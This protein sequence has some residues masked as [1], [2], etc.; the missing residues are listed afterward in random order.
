M[1]RQRRDSAC[2]ALATGEDRNPRWEGACL[3]GTY[4]SVVCQ[5]HRSRETMNSGGQ[6]EA[7]LVSQ[8]HFPG[9]LP[10]PYGHVGV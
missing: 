5:R 1:L 6:G 10:E 7:L 3:N 8:A 9:S 2:R 4:H